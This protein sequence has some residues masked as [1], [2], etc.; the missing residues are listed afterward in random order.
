[1]HFIIV[2]LFPLLFM[3]TILSAPLNVSP[4]KQQPTLQSLPTYGSCINVSQPNRNSF[5][6]YNICPERVYINVCARDIFGE[7][8]LYRSGRTIPVGGRYT[9]FT[10]YET[11]PQGIT[12]AVDPVNPLVPPPCDKQGKLSFAKYYLMKPII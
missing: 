1:M 5:S 2:L 7:T 9:I 3:T 8:K 10:F 4:K 11:R 6:F 12:W